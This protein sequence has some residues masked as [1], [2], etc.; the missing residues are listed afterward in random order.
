MEPVKGIWYLSYQRAAKP[1]ASLCIRI[2]T[3]TRAF[4]FSHIKSLEVEEDFD[5]E[6]DL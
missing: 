2:R 5:Q 1:Q 6:L 3:L 4:A